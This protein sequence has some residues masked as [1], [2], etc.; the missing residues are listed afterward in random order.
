[1]CFFDENWWFLMKNDEFSCFLMIFHD[2]S[3]I[4]MI[5]HVFDGFWWKSDEK[6]M[7]VTYAVVDIVP[8]SLYAYICMS[9]SGEKQWKTWKWWFFHVF[10]VFLCFFVIF[11]VF[12]ENNKNNIFDEKWWKSNIFVFSYQLPAR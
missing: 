7:K 10:C 6:H 3:S 12:C 4:F 2:F 1:M 5:F 9:T 11:Y 8:I